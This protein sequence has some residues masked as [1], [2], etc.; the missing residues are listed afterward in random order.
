MNVRN[1]FSINI[2]L[3]I[4]VLLAVG[5]LNAMFENFLSNTLNSPGFSE[6]VTNLP[7]GLSGSQTVAKGI[8]Q[9]K[10]AI[11]D[12]PG[13]R[14]YFDGKVA[15]SDDNGFYS[16]PVDDS[17]LARYRLVVT[18]RLEHVFDKNNTI[19]NFKIIPDKDYIC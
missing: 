16:F 17:D 4:Y 6:R 18:R 15:V 11:E 13:F 2:Y 5:T 7:A 14:V 19:N 1:I 8:I 9:V 3:I 10:S 12:L